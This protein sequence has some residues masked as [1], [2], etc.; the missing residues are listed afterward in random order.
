MT[1]KPLNPAKFFLDT[2]LQKEIR[3]WKKLNDIEASERGDVNEDLT[4]QDD[5]EDNHCIQQGK[6]KVQ[7]DLRKPEPM[8]EWT[9]KT[10]EDSR[11]NQ[12]RVPV[13]PSYLRHYI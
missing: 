13:V 4:R 5:D 6:V 12:S 3:E 10:R 7:L 11:P 8:A 2:S 9:T 1:R